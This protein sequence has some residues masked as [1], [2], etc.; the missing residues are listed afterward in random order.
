[1]VKFVFVFFYGVWY[2]L[3]CWYCVIVEFEQV[4]YKVVVF[5]LFFL[6]F[7]LF[8]FDWFKDVEIIYQIVLDFVKW[9]DVVVVIYSFSG[10]I[11]G[12]VLEGLDKDI[13]MFRGLKGGV[14]RFIYIIVFFVLEGF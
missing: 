13:C 14:I 1:M 3:S 6:G 2:G 5:V 7:M 10:M 11:G 9:Q 8:I 12:I 4:G